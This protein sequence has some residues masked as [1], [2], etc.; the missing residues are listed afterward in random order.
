MRFSS[1]LKRRPVPALHVPVESVFI[2]MNTED[3][4]RSELHRLVDSLPES[5]FDSAKAVL[6][7]FQVWPPQ[8]PPE[9]KR[10][11]EIRQ[12]HLERMRRSRAP[13]TGGGSG[14]GGIVHPGG[15]GHCSHSSIEDGAS[16]L[17]SY[18]FYEGHEIF[19][20]QRLRLSEDKQ[21]IHYAHGVKGP[22]GDM[23]VNEM[24]LDVG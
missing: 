23:H 3:M 20:I 6:E 15:Y 4:D 7:H 16:V 8:P 10:I 11:E 5:A 24:V 17:E 13:G 14:V 12:E 18:H 21:S 19:V 9:M 1:W 22:K 2:D